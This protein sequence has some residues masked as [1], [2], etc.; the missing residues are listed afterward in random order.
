MS[1]ECQ[2]DL[3]RQRSG[4]MSWFKIWCALMLLG[5]MAPGCAGPASDRTGFDLAAPPTERPL[6]TIISGGAGWQVSLWTSPNP[7]R[8]GA[9]DVL[10]HFVD[11]VGEA[12]NGLTLH[13]VPWMPAHGHGGPGTPAVIAGGDG[14]YL[15][16]PVNL[17][18][19][20]RWELR[21]TVD[22]FADDG[23]VPT[24]DVP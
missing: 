10:F 9:V 15:V 8:K 20:G 14:W 1:A 4:I 12:L 16:R 6:A 2:V 13:M 21:T 5:A 24:I 18:M 7:P 19:S 11:G 17:H 23:V 3:A 22:G